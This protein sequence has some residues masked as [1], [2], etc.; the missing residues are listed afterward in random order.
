MGNKWKIG[1]VAAYYGN[2]VR[3]GIPRL[4]IVL[5]AELYDPTEANDIYW[6]NV[7]FFD[8]EESDGG[9]TDKYCRNVGNVTEL[10][11]KIYAG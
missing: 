10:E 7:H 2:S 1:D 5:A 6:I 11:K 8:S 3:V 4:G 9:F